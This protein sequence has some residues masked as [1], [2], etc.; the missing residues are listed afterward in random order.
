MFTLYIIEFTFYLLIS[1]T[2]EQ[3]LYQKIIY[4]TKITV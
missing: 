4:F 2:F 1:Y 3:F